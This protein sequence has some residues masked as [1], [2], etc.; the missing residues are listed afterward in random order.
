MP[1]SVIISFSLHMGSCTNTY[2]GKC[3]K[4]EIP[5]NIHYQMGCLHH[6]SKIRVHE[7]LWN[8][9]LENYKT[10]RCWVIPRNQCLPSTKEMTLEVKFIRE[11]N[12]SLGSYKQ[13]SSTGKKKTLE[14]GSFELVASRWIFLWRHLFALYCCREWECWISSRVFNINNYITPVRCPYLGWIYG[15]K[16]RPMVH[17]HL[18]QCFYYVNCC[19]C[20]HK[21]GGVICILSVLFIWFSSFSTSF[22]PLKG[23]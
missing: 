2:T 8:N 19:H 18:S 6:N 9:R 14:F 17:L 23:Q 21:F 3:T 1:H 4:N 12:S 11:S 22:I 15:T 10:Q 7:S 13:R 16:T 5:W 20:A